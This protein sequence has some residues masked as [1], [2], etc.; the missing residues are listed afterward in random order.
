MKVQ[1]EKGTLSMYDEIHTMSWGVDD[2]GVDHSAP[3]IHRLQASEA[4]F[5]EL[6]VACRGQQG[7]TKVGPPGPPN[8]L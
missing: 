8:Q 3:R 5:Q 1:S 6:P 4:I 2:V 7:A